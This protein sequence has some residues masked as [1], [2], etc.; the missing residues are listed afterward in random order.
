MSHGDPPVAL[1]EAWLFILQSNDPEL[2]SDKRRAYRAI[3]DVFGSL[4]LAESYVDKS[5]NIHSNN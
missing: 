2:V 5:K 4:E 1:I 3:R